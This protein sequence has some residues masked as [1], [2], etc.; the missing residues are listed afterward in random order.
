MISVGGLSI[1]KTQIAE[2]IREQWKKIGI[3]ADVKEL[4]RTLAFKRD[5][6]NENQ[7]LLW[8]NDGS[9]WLYLFP[10]HVLPVDPSECHMGMAIA[11][12]YASNGAQ[13]KAPQGEELKKALEL[14]RAAPSLK[15]DEQVRQAKE[16]WKLVVEGCWS[17]G[18]VGQ[19]PAFMG[20][21]IVSNKMG[22]V[23]DRQINAQHCR[24]PGSSQPATFYI[25]A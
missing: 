11:K 10:R 15:P 21:R 5:E 8:A 18:T 16:I 25:K 24:T 19:S 20:V 22:N 4:E 9:E 17:I 23:P 13:G 3:Q 14:F 7:I 1:T 6:S 12:W 2:M